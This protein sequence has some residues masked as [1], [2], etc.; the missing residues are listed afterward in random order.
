MCMLIPWEGS[1]RLTDGSDLSSSGCVSNSR[2]EGSHLKCMH[3]VEMV[4]HLITV[5]KLSASE[6]SDLAV[7]VLLEGGWDD[8][9]ASPFIIACIQGCG[10]LII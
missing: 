2:L 3:E 7:V 8:S 5:C 10:D 4:K 6:L 1:I 9:H